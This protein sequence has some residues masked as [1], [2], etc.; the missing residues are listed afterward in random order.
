MTR[1]RHPDTSRSLH[2]EELARLD[3][4]TADE[5]RRDQALQRGEYIGLR[6][7]ANDDSALFNEALERS[8]HGDGQHGESLPA[9][10]SGGS[11]AHAQNTED[12]CRVVP[13]TNGSADT[14]HPGAEAADRQPEHP[15]EALDA[16]A[17]AAVQEALKPLPAMRVHGGPSARN[18]FEESTRPPDRDAS[19]GGRRTRTAALPSETGRIAAA[20]RGPSREEA[21]ADEPQPGS[22]GNPASNSFGAVGAP[23]SEREHHDRERRDD[24]SRE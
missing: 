24:A 3:R 17:T 8:L 15:A 11:P 12:P 7:G 5:V 10:K 19:A 22:P 1:E 21:G 20:P 16:E 6:R 9:F 2:D 13:P 4:S 18:T 23:V 14:L